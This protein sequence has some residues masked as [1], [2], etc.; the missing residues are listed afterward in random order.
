[1]ITRVC[2]GILSGNDL[3]F[4]RE[5]KKISGQFSSVPWKSRINWNQKRWDRTGL[6]YNWSIFFIL[7]IKAFQSSTL[8]ASK[9]NKLCSS[10]EDIHFFWW[11]G[12][13]VFSILESW[14]LLLLRNKLFYCRNVKQRVRYFAQALRPEKVKFQSHFSP[15]NF[16]QFILILPHYTTELWDNG[17]Y[18]WAPFSIHQELQV[19]GL[20][21]SWWCC[22]LEA[23]GKNSSSQRVVK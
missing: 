14:G 8:V 19:A 1:M 6:C 4:D 21:S 13:S 20:L 15:N 11:W 17:C 9:Y 3:P 12:V 18:Q 10:R 5:D 22:I 2:S 23:T 16:V 7:G